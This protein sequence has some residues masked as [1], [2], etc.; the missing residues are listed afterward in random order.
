MSIKVC[1]MC[2]CK[3]SQFGR[4][5]WCTT[6]YNYVSLSFL[7]ERE[8]GKHLK[9]TAKKCELLYMQNM[10]DVFVEEKRGVSIVS[11]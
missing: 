2:I 10:E 8:A 3:L 7:C 1:E 4:K 5:W 6:V 11:L 9:V